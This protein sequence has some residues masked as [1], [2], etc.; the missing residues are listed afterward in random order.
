MSEENFEQRE[1]KIV[2]GSKAEEIVKCQQCGK[3]IKVQ[4]GHS[5]ETE[6][7]Q[8]V[9]V[10]ND[11]IAEINRAL[12]DET[13]NPNIIG[14]FL[15]GLLAAIVCGLGWY[16]IVTQSNTEYAIIT[17]VMGWIIGKAVCRGSGHKKGGKLQLMAAIFT[18]LAIIISEL[19]ITMQFVASDQEVNMSISQLFLGATFSGDIFYLLWEVIKAAGPIGLLIWAIGIYWGYSIPRPTKI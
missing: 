9:Y 10:C 13:K 16:F 11:C 4:D 6:D 1:E 17:I 3:E 7:G 18:A 14:A 2:M 5:F 12:E 15:L 8:E 19:F